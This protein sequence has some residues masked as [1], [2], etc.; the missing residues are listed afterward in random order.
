MG[1][2]ISLSAPPSPP[3]PVIKQ[4]PEPATSATGS[5]PSRPR[6]ARRRPA[7]TKSRATEGSD[8]TLYVGVLGPLVVTRGEPV[9]LSPSQ[10]RLV[11]GLA[12]HHPQP[13]STAWLLAATRDADG[14]NP[15]A[16]AALR[17][18]VFRLRARLGDD[19]IT[20]S[21]D[22]YALSPD[23]KV[24][25]TRFLDGA[26]AGRSLLASGHV[27]E[28]ERQLRAARDLWRGPLLADAPLTA[29][30]PENARAAVIA[31]YSVTEHWAEAAIRSG[32]AAEVAAV[33]EGLVA[34]EPLRER[35]WQLLIDAHLSVEQPDSAARAA[36]AALAALE[37]VGITPGDRLRDAVHQALGVGAAAAATRPHRTRPSSGLPPAEPCVG[38]D[39]E[40]D[41][42]L[43][44]VSTVRD[45]GARLVVV[46]GEP[47]VGKSHLV[48]DVANSLADSG[49]PV[50]SGRA[51][52]YD[53]VPYRPIVEML[54]QLVVD[55][56]PVA[57]GRALAG[58]LARL[59]GDETSPAPAVVDAIT[60]R[61]TLYEAIVDLVGATVT[62]GRAL[63]V[64]EDVHWADRDCLLLIWHMLCV[65]P[66]LPVC[67]LATLRDT[68]ELPDASAQIIDDLSLRPTTTWLSLGGLSAQDL[69]A[70]PVLTQRATAEARAPQD[71]AAVVQRVTGG[72][73]LFAIHLLQHPDWSEVLAA[74][75]MPGEL[76]LEPAPDAGDAGRTPEADADGRARRHQSAPVLRHLTHV[77]DAFLARLTEPTR[78]AMKLAA[79]QGVE[80][81]AALLA[82]TLD[83]DASASLEEAERAGV[84]RHRPDGTW[85]FRHHVV[86]AALEDGLSRAGRAERHLRVARAIEKDR[87]PGPSS[88]FSLARHYRIARSIT[89]DDP[90]RRY[91]TEAAERAEA[92]LDF[93]L[94][95]RYYLEAA[96]VAAPARAARLRLRAATALMCEGDVHAARRE[97][98]AAADIALGARD[99]DL[100]GQAAVAAAELSQRLGES[101]PPDVAALL[102]RAIT[103]TDHAPIRNELYLQRVLRAAPGKGIADLLTAG[104]EDREVVPQL[105][106]RAFWAAHPDGRVELAEL[107]ARTALDGPPAVTTNAGVARWVHAVETGTTALDQPP[108]GMPD[109]LDPEMSADPHAA[110]TWWSWASARHAAAGRLPQAR[111]ATETMLAAIRSSGAQ[112]ELRRIAAATYHGQLAFIDALKNPRLAASGPHLELIDPIWT[113]SPVMWQQVRVHNAALVGDLGRARRLLPACSEPVLDGPSCTGSVIFQLTALVQTAVLVRDTALAERLVPRLEPWSGWQAV[114]R[115]H[116]YFGAVDLTLGL[117]LLAAGHL[118]EAIEKLDA[119]LEQHRR[120]GARAWESS[121]LLLLARAHGARARRGDEA[122][123]AAASDEARNLSTTLGLPQTYWMLAPPDPTRTS[124]RR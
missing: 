9:E 62:H 8:S 46:S 3:G 95:A 31:R 28:A 87:G 100:L 12:A 122:V 4:I 92:L 29:D 83:G 47:G 48:A 50:W 43:D 104:I 98:A 64:L 111:T 59:I 89:G 38:R 68:G 10:R 91:A 55:A 74:L 105:T 76:D 120:L 21:G 102:E 13:A 69:A 34:A 113:E 27:A 2:G 109:Q 53:R 118:D 77:I 73:P 40:R 61:H 84:I 72:N 94:A 45:G 101:L 58:P 75:E 85:E 124:P 86:H 42:I 112:P 14:D 36:R 57:V 117:A 106:E 32:E 99:A 11:A 78:T 107:L 52:P 65:R 70:L 97:L 80:F 96:E 17:S 66:D 51:D 24:D 119:S 7:H 49:T 60:E 15:A 18:A 63:I 54:R 35:A 30:L 82:A 81:D 16:R 67:V 121:S 88:P 71:L 33:L 41:R 103:A 39:A 44:V 26:D 114:F 19:A 1:V 25:I 90:A 37:E 108:D 110:W 116:V 56:D 22:A 93:G 79:A 115:H 20:T 6:P 5:S 123:A 23:T